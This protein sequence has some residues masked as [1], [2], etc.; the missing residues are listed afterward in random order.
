MN[1][2][3]LI[4]ML[5]GLQTSPDQLNNPDYLQ[6]NQTTISQGKHILDDGLYHVD[7]SGVIII[8]DGTDGDK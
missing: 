1:F 6:E 5:L 3:I 8:D 4:L 7:E 2:L